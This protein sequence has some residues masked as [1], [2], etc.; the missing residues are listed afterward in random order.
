[1]SNGGSEN[2]KLT[3][4]ENS[5]WVK[6]KARNFTSQALGKQ[7]YYF[8]NLKKRRKL[9]EVISFLSQAGGTLMLQK[10]HSN[11]FSKV[12][13]LVSTKMEQN[14]FIHTGIFV[15]FLPACPHH[16]HFHLQMDTF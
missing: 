12:S 3:L 13:V 10:G 15:F 14:I 11:A 16:L 9:I 6:I 1:V 8:Q 7:L 4:K 5:F 2:P